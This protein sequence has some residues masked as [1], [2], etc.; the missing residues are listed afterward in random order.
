[1]HIWSDILT[2]TEQLKPDINS[3][4]QL[5]F[6]LE[7]FETFSW[8]PLRFASWNQMALLTDNFYNTLCHTCWILSRR[9]IL[10][11]TCGSCL[12]APQP[13]SVAAP[14]ITLRLP[15]LGNGL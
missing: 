1:M 4:F 2:H 6:P 12:M 5:T 10:D 11:E 13:T 7:F 3:I 8:S 14:E 15:A 9:R